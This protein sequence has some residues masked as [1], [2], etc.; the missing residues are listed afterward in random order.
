MKVF[1]NVMIS[2]LITLSLLICLFL[3]FVNIFCEKVVVIGTSMYSTLREGELGLLIKKEIAPKIEREDIIVFTKPRGNESINVV[4]RVI[5]LPGETIEI[6]ED[7]QIYIN[8]QLISQDFLDEYQLLQ[9]Y[10]GLDSSYMKVTLKDDEYYVLGDN[11]FNS[12]DS[13][14]DGP[15]KRKDILG[16]LMFTY[17]QY[18]KFDS[19]TE[20]GEDKQYFPLR[21]FEGGLWIS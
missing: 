19:N 3:S 20:T 14:Y 12:Q 1:K 18:R 8:N 21:F 6:K 5:G 10:V 9:T 7:G 11:R 2:A 16:K 13:R 17:A 4:K 15:I